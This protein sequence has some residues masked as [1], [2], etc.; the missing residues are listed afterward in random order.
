MSRPHLTYVD[1]LRRDTLGL[2]NSEEIGNHMLDRKIWREPNS[3]G[4]PGRPELLGF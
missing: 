3:S 2:D 4:L 1:I